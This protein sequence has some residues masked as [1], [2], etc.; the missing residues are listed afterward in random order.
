MHIYFTK[1]LFSAGPATELA[2]TEVNQVPVASTSSG[3]DVSNWWKHTKSTLSNWWD[4]DSIETNPDTVELEPN[5][6]PNWD[7]MISSS[8]HNDSAQETVDSTPRTSTPICS[9]NDEGND[10]L[11][12]GGR[13]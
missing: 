10:V 5:W 7:S 6:E 13:H 2:N 8:R 9:G 11:S 3:K 4:T 12:Q 1:P